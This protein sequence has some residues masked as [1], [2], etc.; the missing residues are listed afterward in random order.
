MTN[1]TSITG[2]VLSII[3]GVIAL[4]M[5]LGDWLDIYQVPIIMG[6]YAEHTYSI[7]EVEDFLSTFNFYVGSETIES[8]ANFLMVGTV[9][10]IAMNVITMILSFFGTKTAKVFAVISNLTSLIL[11]GVVIGFIYK[12]NAYV[13]DR[14]YG[15]IDELLRL[16]KRPWLLVV[17]SVLQSV[18][19]KIKMKPTQQTAFAPAVN[20][21][22]SQRQCGNCGAYLSEG[23]M[24]CNKCGAKAESQSAAVKYCTSCGGQ[25][26]QG[27]AFCT[28][29]GAKIN[30]ESVPNEG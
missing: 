6:D 10:V 22:M 7:F 13:E 19:L 21:H 30:E 29:C 5:V 8:Y 2:R 18:C 24:F 27:T 14:T 1:K 9:A 28:V 16:T 3:F 23:A 25:I 20:P 15:G 11:A 17:F 4:C 26:I 12:T